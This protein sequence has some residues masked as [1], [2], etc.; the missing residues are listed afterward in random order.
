[1]STIDRV[2][3]RVRSRAAADGSLA[4]RAV[5]VRNACVVHELSRLGLEP[6]T[7]AELN[8]LPDS[9]SLREAIAW[10]RTR[11]SGVAAQPSAPARRP[12]MGFVLRAGTAAVVVLV[13]LAMSFAEVQ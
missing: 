13:G 7:A 8:T 11:A 4:A 9:V 5:R 10:A 3:S 1:M 6:P 2:R 12:V